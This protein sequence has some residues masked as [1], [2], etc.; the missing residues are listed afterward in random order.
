MDLIPSN[1]NLVGQVDM[2]SSRK[3]DR[4]GRLD[5]GLVRIPCGSRLTKYRQKVSLEEVLLVK[6]MKEHLISE[7]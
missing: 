1:E 3:L 4:S 7:V 2:I 5:I 6:V